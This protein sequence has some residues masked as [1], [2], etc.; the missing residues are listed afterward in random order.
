[1]AQGSLHVEARR[2]NDDGP[3]ATG[4]ITFVDNAVDQTT[5]T[6]RIK[7]TF[8]NDDRRLW[9]GQFVNVT[10]A[11]T[12]EP[13]AI[14]VPTAAVQTGQQGP[15]AFVVKSDRSVEFRP[16]VV[17]RTSGE[18]TIVKSGLGPGDIVVTD[19]HLRLTAD[20]HVNIKGEDDPRVGP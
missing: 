16:V 18:E 6:I 15:Y 10:V 9:P 8:P 1:M 2:P 4:R 3:A 12:R 20:S 11:L 7:G 19:G 13:N 5:G 14:V 17:E